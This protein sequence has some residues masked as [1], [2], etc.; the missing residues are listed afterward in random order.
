MAAITIFIALTLA[1]AVVHETLVEVLPVR[2]P[3]ALAR[4][5]AVVVAALFAW[6]I[7][8]SVF[9]AF[10]Q[11]LRMDWMHPVLTGVVLIATGEFVRS[12]IAA[13]AHRAGEPS[14]T[15]EPNLGIRA[16]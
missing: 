9:A 13:V 3:T 12:I 4:T 16:A 5:G 1:L 8:Y 7:D 10:G 11:E 2:M 15:V 14:V 6:G